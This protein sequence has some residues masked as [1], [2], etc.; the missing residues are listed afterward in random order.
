MVPREIHHLG[1][2]ALS[3]SPRPGMK[4]R[5]PTGPQPTQRAAPRAGEECLPRFRGSARSSRRTSCIR[6]GEPDDAVFVTRAASSMDL[7]KIRSRRNRTHKPL[8]EYSSETLFWA[9]ARLQR[10]CGS[11]R[12]GRITRLTGKQRPGLP[13]AVEPRRPRFTQMGSRMVLSS[14]EDAGR[15][16]LQTSVQSL[17]ASLSCFGGW[18]HENTFQPSRGLWG[19]AMAPGV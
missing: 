10:I 3:G 7:S 2:R 4:S 18:L 19:Q 15:G 16:R 5:S 8:M 14:E 6:A 13:P 1:I 17:E 11:S 12:S 9:P